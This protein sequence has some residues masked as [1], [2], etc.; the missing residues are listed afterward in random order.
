[1][2]KLKVLTA[3][4]GFP[5]VVVAVYYGGLVL[6]ALVVIITLLALAEYISLLTRIGY[7]PIPS[8][9]WG[10][11]FALLLLMFAASKGYMEGYKY[12][13]SVF[14]VMA[15]WTAIIVWWEYP[16]NVLP[17]L[18]TSF[19]GVFYIAGMLGHL[20]FLRNI[21]PEGWAYV[22]FT[23]IVTWASDTGAFFAGT[24]FGRHKLAPSISPGK[25]WEGVGGG[26]ILA[27]IAGIA[28]GGW[29]GLPMVWRVIIAVLISLAAVVGDLFESALKRHA[30]LKDSGTLLPGHGGVLDRFDSLFLTAPLVYYIL[31]LF[32]I[33]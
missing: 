26:I 33:E 9:V 19:F 21:A 11:S 18:T 7:K 17:C 14:F 12:L 16:K 24:R 29:L 4:I 1:V 15:L 5:I 8:L 27:M 2:L 30:G 25:T 13:P 3:V 20:F 28:L 32:I 6:F 23:I 22:L 31:V 10:S